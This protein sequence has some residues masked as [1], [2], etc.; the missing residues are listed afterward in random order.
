MGKFEKLQCI[1][2]KQRLVQ[3]LKCKSFCKDIM[4]VASVLQKEEK[5]LLID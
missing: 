5:L 2:K 4:P 3:Q 1:K